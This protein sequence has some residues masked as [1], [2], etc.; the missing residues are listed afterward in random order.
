MPTFH[1]VFR[2]H[3]YKRELYFSQY[4]KHC[5]RN[6]GH[7]HYCGKFNQ[8]TV[9]H[10]LSESGQF[11]ED[12]TKTCLLTFFY[13]TILGFSKQNTASKCHKMA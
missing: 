11:L 4:S 12:V 10:I 9:Y 6:T 1:F 7:I 2:S 3:L 13:D 8:D 5:W